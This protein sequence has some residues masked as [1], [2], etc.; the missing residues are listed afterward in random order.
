MHNPNQTQSTR[1]GIRLLTIISVLLL[2]AG[3]TTTAPEEQSKR[4]EFLGDISDLEPVETPRLEGA[5]LFVRP[6]FDLKAYD[7]FYLLKPVVYLAPDAGSSGVDPDELKELADYFYQVGME[8]IGERYTVVTEPV[9]GALIVRTAITDVDPVSSAAN[10]AGK[11]ALK[12]VTLDLGGAS[13]E[14]EFID[15]DSGQRM[16]AIIDTRAGQRFGFGKSQM[17]SMRRWG[18]AKQAFQSWAT[19]FRERLDELREQGAA[20]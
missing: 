6:G 4:S 9:P 14:G 11:L 5:A 15:V 2:A 18:H 19:S 12:V 1:N 3:C 13:I 8:K 17:D 7:K 10:I 20:Q 16:L